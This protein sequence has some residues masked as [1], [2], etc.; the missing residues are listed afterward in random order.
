MRSSRARVRRKR[1]LRRRFTFPL[2]RTGFFSIAIAK[3][4]RIPLKLNY[5]CFS[6]VAPCRLLTLVPFV[7]P[8]GIAVHQGTVFASINQ[9]AL[10]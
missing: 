2:A 6:Q 9:I 5:T 3:L 1:S 10:H 4:D 8:V 7:T